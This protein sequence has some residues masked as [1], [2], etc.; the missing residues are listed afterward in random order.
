MTLFVADEEKKALIESG[1]I[2][3]DDE[4]DTW[5]TRFIAK[6]VRSI[7][8]GFGARDKAVRYRCTQIFESTIPHLGLI[9]WVVPASYFLHILTYTPLQRGLVPP[10]PESPVRTHERQRSQHPLERS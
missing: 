1:D 3:R 6:V 10:T 8:Q 4:E 5:A 9:E 2:D 7:A